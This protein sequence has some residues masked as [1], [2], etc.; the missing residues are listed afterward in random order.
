MPESAQG[1]GICVLT[2]RRILVL[3]SA[4]EWVQVIGFVVLTYFK[5][6]S[7]CTD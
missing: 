4:Y 3:L 7:T 5:R 2:N 1:N 6:V